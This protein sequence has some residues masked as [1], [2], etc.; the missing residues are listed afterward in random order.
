M[1]MSA[2]QLIETLR[3]FV[4]DHGDLPV[5]MQDYVFSSV[6]VEGVQISSPTHFTLLPLI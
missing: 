1:Q 3:T 4:K 5:V 6:E 2:T